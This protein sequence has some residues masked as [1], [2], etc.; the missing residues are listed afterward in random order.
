MT[1]CGNETARSPE[2][3]HIRQMMVLVTG[4]AG[5]LGSILVRRLLANGHPVRVVDSF[6]YGD[7]ALVD[8]ASDPLLQ[9]VG[10]NV[11]DPE[12]MRRAMHGIDAVVHLAA[13]VG[14]PACALLPDLAT[15]TNLDATALLAELCQ[16]AGVSRLVFASTC[17]VYGAGKTDLTEESPVNPMSHYAGTKIVAERALLASA[18]LEFSPVVLR[19]ATIYG[20]APRLRFDLAANLLTARA[21][22]SGEITI[23]G[24]DQ[25]RPVLHVADAARA[26][27][28]A[29]HVPDDAAGRIYNVGS[30]DEN[31]RL[32]DLGELIAEIVPGAELSLDESV[33]D[34]RTYH[35]R[36]N[37]FLEATGFR[38]AISLR[39]GLIELRDYLAA[40]PELDISDPRWDNARWLA[41]SKTGRLA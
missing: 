15:S 37:R 20:L 25:W 38:P 6:L 9:V 21:V 16:A 32:R 27:E 2:R 8:L 24:G 10:G 12:T 40:R 3:R 7:D 36:F 11:S 35:V 14:D 5:Y 17:S 31:Y 41:L 30:S 26:I 23:H 18:G 22:R 39:Q 29:I 33:H 34:R 19:F 28:E 4:G 1:E 13:I